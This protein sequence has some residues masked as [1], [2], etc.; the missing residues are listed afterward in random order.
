MYALDNV[1]FISPTF[2]IS[3][4]PQHIIT[5]YLH[6]TAV[7]CHQWYENT[8]AEKRMRTMRFN[9]LSNACD[10][11]GLSFSTVLFLLA[12]AKCSRQIG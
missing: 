10:V 2:D 7:P 9:K 12:N 8:P 1:T 5:L 11:A 4:I 6:Y 3:H